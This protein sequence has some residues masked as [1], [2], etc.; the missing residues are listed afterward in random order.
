VTR[1]EY[2]RLENELTQEMAASAPTPEADRTPRPIAELRDSGLLWLINRAVFHP[3]GFALALS[4]HGGEVV[5]WKLL[6]DGSEPWQF[7]EGEDQN[8][9]AAEATLRDA[10]GRGLR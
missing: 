1:V 5:G 10:G 9:A 3:R 2:E 8:F 4:Y 7:G 6:G